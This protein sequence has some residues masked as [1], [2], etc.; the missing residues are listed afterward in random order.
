MQSCDGEQQRSG[1]L[2]KSCHGPLKIFSQQQQRERNIIIICICVRAPIAQR[3]VP[4][5]ASCDL[6]FHNYDWVESR[7]G[8]GGLPCQPKDANR[9]DERVTAVK[10]GKQEQT[11]RKGESRQC[12][13][14][15]T[16]N[17][18][19]LL[20]PQAQTIRGLFA[21]R[22]PDLTFRECNRLH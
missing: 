5:W 19:C 17:C 2:I 14:F 15:M 8:G 12:W 22:R 11:D 18:D 16:L 21:F 4:M 6:T 3:P 13:I 7:D 9:H 1:S 10:V 20:V